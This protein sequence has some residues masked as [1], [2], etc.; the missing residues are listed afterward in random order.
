MSFFSDFKYSEL[1][2]PR[3]H[4]PRD[5]I[6]NVSTPGL[7]SVSSAFFRNV[8]RTDSFSLFP[9]HVAADALQER[10]LEDVAIWKVTGR[11]SARKKK[12]TP[13]QQREISR[14]IQKLRDANVRQQ[15]KGE[16]MIER[17]QTEGLPFIEGLLSHQVGAAQ[18]MQ[19]IMFSI[20]VET[21]I[22]F[23][24]LAADLW[25]AALDYGP[26]EW[27]IPVLEQSRKFKKG[28]NFEKRAR[29]KT[30]HDPQKAY[31]SYLRDVD[32]VSFQKLAYIVFWYKTAFGTQI[33]KLFS[34]IEGG[35]IYALSAVRNVIVHK[36]GKADPLFLAAIKE[37]PELVKN[38]FVRLDGEIVRR[39]RNTAIHL[40]TE[41]VMF[42]DKTITP[43]K[44]ES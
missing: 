30:I 35:Y 39:L 38:D 40:A 5:R 7:A 21:W 14:I 18:S 34:D 42:V 33:P 25:Y 43:A 4:T 13:K 32:K 6:L 15:L 2:A 8:A 19:A 41:L 44:A 31:G 16:N 12:Y 20:V 28:S 23:E 22:A 3:K 37:F 11:L 10:L 27:R 29:P 17:R 24:T 9:A 26:K 36:A 1:I